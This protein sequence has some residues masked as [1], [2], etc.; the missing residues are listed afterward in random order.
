MRGSILPL[1]NFKCLA[2]DHGFETLAKLG[3]NQAK[4]P[5]CGSLHTKKELSLPSSASGAL[6]VASVR[7]ANSKTPE[8]E[9]HPPHKG[10]E[11]QH[12]CSGVDKLIKKYD[13]LHGL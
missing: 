4:C 11:C 7:Q 13:K 2:C 1:Y 12:H 5:S 6:R 10:G 8:V 9:S 3:S